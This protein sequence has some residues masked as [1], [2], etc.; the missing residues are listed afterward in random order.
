[1][2]RLNHIRQ[3]DLSYNAL[4]PAG[5]LL[6]AEGMKGNLRR[7]TSLN[8]EGNSMGEKAGVQICSGVKGMHAL[9]TF[10]IARNKIG[11]DSVVALGTSCSTKCRDM[12]LDIS[13]NL[14]GDVGFE[15]I[16]KLV[17]EKGEDGQKTKLN[18]P[19]TYTPTQFFAYCSLCSPQLRI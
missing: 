12:V 13:Y 3:L 9:K 18:I 8:L 4:G 11:D 6:L 10:N 7:L 14:V 16:V 17:V 1:M 5:A 2:S 15:G 19:C